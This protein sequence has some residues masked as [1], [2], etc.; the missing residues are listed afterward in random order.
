MYLFVSV[1]MHNTE[2]KNCM[3]YIIADWCIIG[4][5]V[6]FTFSLFIYMYICVYLRDIQSHSNENE[7]R[8]VIES[9][10]FTKQYQML[11]VYVLNYCVWQTRR[12]YPICA[13]S[14]STVSKE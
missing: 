5:L 8:S 4:W 1:Y 14:M 11:N 10:I 6:V 9:A 7:Q 3:F 2:E 13:L 12:L